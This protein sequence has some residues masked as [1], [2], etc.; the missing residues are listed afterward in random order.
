LDIGTT[1]HFRAVATN[2]VGT[3]YGDD[4]IFTTLALPAVATTQTATGTT[5]G[6][7]TLHGLA[8]PNA[9][10][11]SGFFEWGTTTNYGNTTPLTSL[12]GGTSAIPASAVLT[13]LV[14][15]VTYHFRFAAS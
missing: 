11:A 4:V 7:A 2:A 6:T 5:N 8:V 13:N 9:A 15:G 10:D 3:N 12:G 1:Y 14:S